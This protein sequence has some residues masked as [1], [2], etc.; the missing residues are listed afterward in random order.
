MS[1]WWSSWR[2]RVRVLARRDELVFTAHTE[3]AVAPIVWFNSAGQVAAVG[4]EEGAAFAHLR[5]VELLRSDQTLAWDGEQGKAAVLL[6][7]YAIALVLQPDRRRYL[8]RPIIEY[9][10]DSNSLRDFGRSRG[11]RI[12]DFDAVARPA[13]ALPVVV[14]ALA[15][16]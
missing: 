10:E 9:A 14:P 13:G 1:G 11:G 2:L 5:R 8:F 15:A 4:K 3:F 7:R 12:R 6:L 16:V